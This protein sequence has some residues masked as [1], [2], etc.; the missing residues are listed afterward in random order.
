MRVLML[1]VAFL[2]LLPVD[3]YAIPA[4]ARQ[5]N[6]S[7]TLCHRAYPEL[8]EFGYQF[9]DNGY[10]LGD[11]PPAELVL[12][13]DRGLDLA[14]D[15]PLAIRFQGDIVAARDDRPQPDFQLPVIAKIFSGAALSK[16][17]NYY[18]Y[19]LLA[20]RGDVAGLEDAW[21]NIHDAPIE[22]LG[23]LLGQFQITD[24]MF[25]RELRLTR[26]DYLIYTV[27][28]SDTGF[29]LT[30]Q[31]GAIASYGVGPVG[32]DVGVAN[33]NGL[34]AANPGPGYPGRNNPIYDNDLA[35]IGFGR[36][37]FGLEGVSVGLFGLKGAEGMKANANR[38][39]RIGPD[40]EWIVG[41]VRVFAQYLTGI[42]DNPT[43]I[44]RAASPDS[45]RISGGFAGFS[46]LLTD[47]WVAAGLYNRV[48]SERRERN[49]N[50]A[51]LTASYYWR[52]NVKL[53]LEGNYDLLPERSW[54]PFQEHSVIA[55][56]DFAY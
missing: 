16:H 36:V 21:I 10:M 34:A 24:L 17:I 3:A 12:A 23:L 40:A 47:R 20:E 7:C 41:P 28:Q 5:L 54:H 1:L 4:F 13:G 26:Q 35:K 56:V 14:K 19:F 18:A 44:A 27:P 49:A 9:A 52:R 42:D 2:I 15:F 45:L 32:L 37:S 50:L 11:A 31:R 29:R 30:Y 25:P 22:G 46:Y 51:T 6:T 43:L 33:G 39:W 48:V 53:G 38:V 8:N 55:F